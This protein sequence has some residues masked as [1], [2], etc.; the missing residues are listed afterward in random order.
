MN[1]EELVNAFDF[2]DERVLDHEIDDISLCDLNSF[3]FQWQGN[4][5]LMRDPLKLQLAA[6]AGV[7]AGFKET[8]A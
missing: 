4:F 8:W 1:R 5:A 6:K 7:I 3:V 2:D